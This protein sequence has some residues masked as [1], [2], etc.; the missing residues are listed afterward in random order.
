MAFHGGFAL[1]NSSYAC[2]IPSLDLNFW[3]FTGQRSSRIRHLV[4][5]PGTLSPAVATPMHQAIAI[6]VSFDE[7]RAR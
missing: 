1:L 7:P 6:A 4:C 5:L 3:V 2:L